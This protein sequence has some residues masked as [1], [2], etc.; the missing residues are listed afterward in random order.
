MSHDILSAPSRLA[1]KPRSKIVLFACIGHCLEL[2]EHTLYAVML[3]FLV[4]HFLPQQNS[5]SLNFAFISLVLVFMVY[6]IGAFFWGTFSDKYGRLS[7]LRFTLLIMAFPAIGIALLPSYQAIGIFAPLT[8]VF[9][10]M[11]QTFSASGE[12]MGARIFMLETLGKN[13]YGMAS[14]VTTAVGGCGVLIAMGMGYLCASYDNEN[15]WRIPFLVGSGLFLVGQWIR[16]RLVEN[17]NLSAAPQKKREPFLNLIKV[18]PINSLCVLTLGAMVGITSYLM[19]AFLN[20]FLI[21]QGNASTWVYQC[22]VIGLFCTMGGALIGGYYADRYKNAYSFL[23]QVLL[24]YGA[25]SVPLFILLHQGQWQIL[26]S[27]MILGGLLGLYVTL[28]GIVMYEAFSSDMRGRGILFNYALGCSIFGS[29]TPLIFNSVSTIHPC[30][31]GILLALVSFSVL[32][33]VK[34]CL[35]R[36]KRSE[37]IYTSIK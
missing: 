8:L 14:G 26:L 35:S 3:P 25:L 33:I 28:S 24:L 15:I 6:P 36:F 16:K 19:Y 21:K 9:L 29:L 23:Y 7:M 1:V 11:V 37:I 30:L 18:Y 34:G 22:A 31:P 17:L 10:R 32:F 13:H 5:N 27:I 20:P 2:Y 4:T 12:V